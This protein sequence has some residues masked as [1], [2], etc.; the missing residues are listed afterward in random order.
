MKSWKTTL[1]GSGGLVT[2]L[3]VS[4]ISPMFDGD[5]NT[6]ADWTPVLPVLSLAAGLFFAR[7]NNVTSEN[8]GA[9]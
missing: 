5:P 1:F 7:D 9:K 4:V 6:A 2:V 8:A 3:Y